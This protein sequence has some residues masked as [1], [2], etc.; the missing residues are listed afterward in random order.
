ME[1]N[2]VDAWVAAI[3]VATALVALLT[4]VGLT[5]TLRVVRDQASRSAAQKAF[6]EIEAALRDL[7]ARR[8]TVTV[9]Y[10]DGHEE[11]LLQ[12]PVPESPA[13][14]RIVEQALEDLESA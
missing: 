6:E 8:L 9:E 1:L 12:R 5:R 7:R 13:A 14:R 2:A 3:G 4:G 10:E 11:K